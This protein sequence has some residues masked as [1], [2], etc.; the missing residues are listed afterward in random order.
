MRK[1]E[2]GGRRKGKEGDRD[3]RESLGSQGAKGKG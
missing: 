2:R 1:K 3:G